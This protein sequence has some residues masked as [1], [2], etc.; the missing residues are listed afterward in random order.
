MF[1]Q[2][3]QKTLCFI[4]IIGFLYGT[5]SQAQKTEASND[6]PA[7]LPKNDF[8]QANYPI[9]TRIGN[10]PVV[11]AEAGSLVYNDLFYVFGGISGFIDKTQQSPSKRY[12]I[13]FTNSAEYFDPKTQQWTSITPKPG[14]GV[15]HYG[16]CLVDDQ[17]WLAGGRLDPDRALTN[18]V[19][20]YDLQKDTWTPG[21]SLPHKL[22]SGALLKLG[23]KLHFFAG[24]THSILT[25]TRFNTLTKYH[26]ILDLD[27]IK[28][29]WQAFESNF[30]T[31][32]QTI[33]ASYL[34]TR[35]KFYLI[36]GQDGH[37]GGNTDHKQVYEYNPAL[38]QWRRLAN[39]P[40]RNSHNE[41]ATFIIDSRLLSI[42]GEHNG[43]KIL[44]YDFEKNR[45]QTIDSLLN[46]CG[47]E[48]RLIGPSA[49]VIDN[50]LIIAGGGLK[51]KNYRSV[52]ATYIKNFARRPVQKIGFLPDTLKVTIARNQLDVV[53]QS[54]WVWT[55]GGKKNYQLN[56]ENMPAW[57]RL[58]GETKRVS[59]ENSDEL[60][61]SFNPRNPS[62]DN[63]TFQIIAQADSGESATLVIEVSFAP[64]PM[65]A[66]AVLSPPVID[67][68]I[69][70]LT[71]LLIF[72]LILKYIYKKNRPELVS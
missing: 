64:A 17:V 60:E 15:S 35:G 30:P 54:A 21:P 26:L 39:L 62:A 16:I 11:K 52:N 40:H 41:S 28:Q 71:L 18:E 22:A 69:L 65:W 44:E 7:L 25:E 59:D 72:L 66:E 61:F 33:H 55:L 14:R 36:G 51:S 63:V 29:G 20:I 43:D 47:E 45:W 5:P 56:I 19:W 6:N 32:A 23:R 38:N 2:F 70:L 58:K 1:G 24:G 68:I 13:V 27:N 42:A 34:N 10:A 37:D 31:A 8:R 9:W 50:Q 4:V 3:C 67:S 53:K 57:V 46:E 12:R 48:M 49:K